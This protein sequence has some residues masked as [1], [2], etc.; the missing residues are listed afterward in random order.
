M[1]VSKKYLKEFL[2]Q[3][4]LDKKN[5]VYDESEFKI[6]YR[7][8]VFLS[9]KCRQQCINKKISNKKQREGEVD[10][11]WWKSY[12]QSE[13]FKSSQKLYR[14]SEKFK[15]KNNLYQQSEKFKLS[16]KEINKRH[17]TKVI[18][19]LDDSYIIHILLQTNPKL[20][21]EII[22]SQPHLIEMK[23]SKIKLHREIIKNNNN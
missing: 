17:S 18:S 6:R 14:Q 8:Y 7:K 11:L 20:S 5:Q 10:K 9:N 3:L 1:K 22:K 19:N 12:R 15:L 13:K 4:I 21:K 16:R 23:R 2:E